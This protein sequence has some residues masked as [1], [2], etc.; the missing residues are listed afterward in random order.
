L[1]EWVAKGVASD[2]RDFTLQLSSKADLKAYKKWEASLSKHKQGHHPKTLI[3]IEMTPFLKTLHLH[4]GIMGC[5][6]SMGGIH[7][8]K[9]LKSSPLLGPF[10]VSEF[11]GF[12]LLKIKIGWVL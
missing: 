2:P 10:G 5:H 6:V 3:C 4:Y 11:W 12:P 7:N 1:N 9:A 8:Y